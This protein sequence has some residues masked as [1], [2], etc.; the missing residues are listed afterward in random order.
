MFSTTLPVLKDCI[1]VLLE[2]TPPEIDIDALEKDLR[3]YTGATE[4]HDLH[5]WS[6][7]VGNYSLSVHLKGDDSLKILNRAT[8]ICH[9]K[10]NILHTT[11]QVEEVNA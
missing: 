7:S 6:I 4:L 10:Y 2:A 11:I 3:F 1:L 9:K 8:E 5:V